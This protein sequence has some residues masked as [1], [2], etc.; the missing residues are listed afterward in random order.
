MSNSIYEFIKAAVDADGKLPDNFR[1]PELE[2]DKNKIFADGALDGIQIYHMGFSV[3]EEDDLNEMLDILRIANGGDYEKASEK[4]SEYCVKHRAVTIIDELQK[5][6]LDHKDEF[7][8]QTM[9]DFSYT[10][11]TESSDR[12][13]IKAGL[14]ILE[15]VDTSSDQELMDIIRILGLSDEFT[16]FSVFDMRY[17]P[18]GQMEILALAGKVRGWGRIHCVRFI[19]P[20]NDEIIRWLLINGIDNDVMSEYSALTVFNKIGVEKMLDSTDL[21]AQAVK[22][23]LKIIDSM[24]VE[25]PVAG[26]SAVDDPPMLLSKVL[27]IAKKYELDDEE[28]KIIDDVAE[29]KA[30]FDN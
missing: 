30:Q 24:L 29:L 13:L 11:I 16:I 2:D 19:E 3:L 28:K 26:I 22:G 1:L 20:E 7:D 23:I 6:I 8:L 4:L 15:L 17:W 9:V 18:D 14:I 27:D 5:T 25:G 12:E 10:L 21:D